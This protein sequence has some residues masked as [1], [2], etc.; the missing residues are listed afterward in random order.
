MGWL[1]F[2]ILITISRPGFRAIDNHF[3]FGLP[4]AVQFDVTEEQ[5]CLHL[6]SSKE[7]GLKFSGVVVG[8]FKWEQRIKRKIRIQPQDLLKIFLIQ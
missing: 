2:G 4:L 7:Y 3:A 5:R 6:T 1:L 8:R